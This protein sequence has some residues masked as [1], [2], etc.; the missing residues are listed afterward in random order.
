MSSSLEWEPRNR[1]RESLPDELKFV[2]RKRYGEPVSSIIDDSD[3]AYLAGLRDAGIEGAEDLIE[4]INKYG[5]IH[6]KEHY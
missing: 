5:E 1:E 6:V 2:L 4:A 3:L